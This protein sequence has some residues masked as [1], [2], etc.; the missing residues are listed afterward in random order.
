MG[1]IHP[2]TIHLIDLWRLQK[3]GYPF[4]KND[5]SYQEWIDLGIAN[6]LLER[7]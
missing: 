2:W 6:Q 5:L 4:E 3:A 7:K 1:D